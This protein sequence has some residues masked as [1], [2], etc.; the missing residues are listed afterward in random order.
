V[1]DETNLET[2]GTWMALGRECPTE[3]TLPGDLQ[4]W[5]GAVLD[6]GRSMLERDKNHPCVLMWS[7]GNES[8]GGSTLYALSEW[9]RRRDP[10][11]LVHYEGIFHDRSYPDTSD[12]ESRMYAKPDE[13][14][15]YL[16]ASPE[17]PYISCEYAHAMGNS[18]GNVNEY[19]ALED[20]FPQYQGGFVWDFIDQALLTEDENGAPYLAAGGDFGTRP[21]DGFL[22]RRRAGVRGQ[23]AVPQA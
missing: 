19:T 8:R 2:H 4:E 22:L 15:E 3:H 6:R 16:A 20:E 1:I 12:I 7:C 17:K 14:R 11:R 23:N 10:S 5:R 18:F 13:I 9:F 21:N